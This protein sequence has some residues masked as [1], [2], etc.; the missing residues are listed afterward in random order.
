MWY[1]RHPY[2]QD[3]VVAARAGDADDCSAAASAG[4][5]GRRTAAT[6][7]RPPLVSAQRPHGTHRRQVLPEPRG[8]Q[9][10]TNEPFSFRQM[11]VLQAI[12]YY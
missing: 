2:V 1:G 7:H 8:A 12:L 6:A 3:V 9:G 4:A 11:T 10:I 5:A